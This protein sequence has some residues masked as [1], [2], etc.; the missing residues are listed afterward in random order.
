MGSKPKEQ[1]ESPFKDMYIPKNIQHN[2]GVINFMYVRLSC[3]SF[4]SVPGQTLFERKRTCRGVFGAL[5]AGLIAG[6]WGVTG[7]GGF[8]FYLAMQAVVSF[9]A[10][11]QH[12]Q[13]CGNAALVSNRLR[14]PGVKTHKCAHLHDLPPT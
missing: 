8:L 10:T 5:V 13:F 6:I 11:A 1:S 3:K 7:W 12:A 2:A 9:L 14:T 4:T